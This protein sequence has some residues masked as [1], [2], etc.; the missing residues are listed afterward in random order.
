M[1]GPLVLLRLFCLFYERLLNGNEPGD[2][3][4]AS[5]EGKFFLKVQ[6]AAS[7]CNYVQLS[8]KYAERIRRVWGGICGRF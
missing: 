3:L 5:T 8:A 4:D 2:Q 1:S 7:G 6:M